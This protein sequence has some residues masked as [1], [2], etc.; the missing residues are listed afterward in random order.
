MAFMNARWNG[1]CSGF[2]LVANGD[3]CGRAI[4][5]IGD[6]EIGGIDVIGM[7]D[8]RAIDSDRRFIQ[9]AEAAAADGARIRRRGAFPRRC[10][11][12]YSARLSE[13]VDR[14]EAAGVRS[15]VSVLMPAWMQPALQFGSST[16]AFE[17]G[18]A[19]GNSRRAA[20]R[21]ANHMPGALRIPDNQMAC[22]CKT[23]GAPSLRGH[24]VS[25]RVP[26]EEPP[27]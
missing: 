15:R 19:G 26:P 1:R 4:V 14:G 10:S 12:Y 8:R 13:I 20:S 7:A 11:P 24:S 25:E 18:M 23:K 6:L 5:P 27:L 3:N 9:T 2:D 17:A 21:P 16:F 22:S